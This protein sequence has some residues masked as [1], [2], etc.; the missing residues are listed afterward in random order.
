[1]IPLLLALLQPLSCH[2]IQSDW[3][4]GRD[5]AAALPAFSAITPDAQI[6]LAPMPGQERTLRIP[7]L[8]RIAMI[9]HLDVEIAEGACFAWSLAVPDRAQ[10][11]A[12]MKKTLAGREPSVEVIDSSLMPVPKGEMIFPLSGLTM[13]SEKAVVWRGFIAYASNRQFPVWA[14]VV[15]SVKGKRLVTATDLRAG[16]PIRLQQIRIESFEGPVQRQHYIADSRQLD[17]RLLRRPVAAGIPLSE[18]M[19]E[20]P[21]EVSRGDVVNAIVETGAARLEVV[22]VAETNGRKGQVI[23]VRNPRSG[24]SFRARVEEKGTVSVVPGGQF[25]LAVEKGKS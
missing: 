19:L 17:G 23:S 12:A 18:D 5:L 15:V 6:S 11:L 20:A 22:A 16:D 3:I 24:R 1:M 8:K 7:E 14:R 13:G 4:Y 21:R 9:N 10:M 25:G 2:L